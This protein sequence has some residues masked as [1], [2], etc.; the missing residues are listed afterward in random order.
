MTSY[1]LNFFESSFF[2]YKNDIKFDIIMGNPPY[3]NSKKVLNDDRRC[4]MNKCNL[5]SLFINI[6]F[7]HFLKEDGYFLFI[8]PC[9][10]MSNGFKFKKIFYENYIIFLNLNECAKHFKKIW[11]TF[12]YYLIQKTNEKKETRVI[13]NYKNLISNESMLLID[14][15]TFL[16]IVLTKESLSICKKIFN[17]NIIKIKS[18]NTKF[19]TKENCRDEKD[20]VFKYPVRYTN[21]IKYSN[22]ECPLTKKNKILL[23]ISGHLYPL[24][25]DGNIGVSAMQFYILTDNK[26]Y[27]DVLNSK[28]FKFILKVTKW[29]G[30]MCHT[31]LQMLPYIDTFNGD[32][33]LFKLFNITDEEIKLINIITKNH[34]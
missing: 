20:D 26:N 23:N 27:V 31:T 5:W 14:D 16:P 24:Y 7:N 29:S 17:S 13:C 12:S 18:H 4:C 2:D 11:S 25:D 32:D 15:V 28:L 30:F 3:Q 1:K 21:T 33:E 22:I 10:W 6:S 19:I 34:I 9:S 8:T